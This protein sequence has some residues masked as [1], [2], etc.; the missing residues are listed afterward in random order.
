MNDCGIMNLEVSRIIDKFVFM[1]FPF[2]KTM[3]NLYFQ[4]YRIISGWI[5]PRLSE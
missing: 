1:T 4:K 2:R 3:I 5:H